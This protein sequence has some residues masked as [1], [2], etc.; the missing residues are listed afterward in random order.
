M[1]GKQR[2]T[3]GN[4]RGAVRVAVLKQLRKDF[5]VACRHYCLSPAA[6]RVA[7]VSAQ[8]SIG[9]ASRCYRAIAGSLVI[10]D[11]GTKIKKRR[12]A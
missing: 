4:L 7:W 11:A 10:P 8:E 2:R 3:V 5:L 6:R 9:K 12:R 1:P